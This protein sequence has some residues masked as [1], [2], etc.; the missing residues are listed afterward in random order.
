MSVLAANDLKSA[1]ALARLD[2]DSAPPVVM[3]PT[4]RDSQGRHVIRRPGAG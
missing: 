2:D 1:N 3:P 4:A